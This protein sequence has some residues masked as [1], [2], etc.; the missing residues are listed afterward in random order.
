MTG[1]LADTVMAVRN[2]EQLARKYQPVVSNPSTQAQTA[3]RAK[4]K[5]LSQ[6]SAVMA[7]VIAMPRAGAVSSRNL[8]TKVNF[9]LTSFAQNTADITL[10]NV[11]LT[12]S[13]VGL[14]A[15]SVNRAASDIVASIADVTAIVNVDRVVYALFEKGADN[16][17]RFVQSMV[18][19]ERGGEYDWRVR[20]ASNPN[21]CLVLAYGVRDNNENAR[22]TFGN[23]EALTAET[24]AKVIVTRTLTE[25]DITL[26]ETKGVELAAATQ[27]R[28]ENNETSSSRKK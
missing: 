3:Q 5:L 24:I 27:S 14:P 16:K 2:G 11:Q 15:I 1:K 9:P 10:A 19:T 22:V 13:V 7:P 8:F 4:M 20:F 28:E 17:L 25:S 18:A 6:L 12:S 21:A 23:L 26:T